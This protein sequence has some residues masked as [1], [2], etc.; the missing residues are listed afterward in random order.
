MSWEDV[1]E[2]SSCMHLIQTCIDAIYRVRSIKII[3]E[4][5]WNRRNCTD[6]DTFKSKNGNKSTKITVL[7]ATS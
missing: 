4:I 1:N 3:Q 2:R 5:I 7:L 6:F